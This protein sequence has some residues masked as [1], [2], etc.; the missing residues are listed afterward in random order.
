MAEIWWKSTIDAYSKVEEDHGL[1]RER[2]VDE[3]H[4]LPFQIAVRDEGAPEWHGVDDAHGLPVDRIPQPLEA[5]TGTQSLTVDNTA[6]GVS[7][8]VPAGA[9]HA[10]ITMTDASGTIRFTDDGTTVTTGVGHQL[11]PG[12]ALDYTSPERDYSRILSRLRFIR[13]DAVSGTLIASY[14]S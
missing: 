9:S 11:Q 8:T 1:A 12:D 6:G 2:A 5:I 10:L 7:L 3:Q 14:Y 13:E 4:P